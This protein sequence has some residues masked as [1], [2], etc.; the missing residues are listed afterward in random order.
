MPFQSYGPC[1]AASARDVA[2]N[3]CD[4]CGH[5]LLRCPGFAECGVLVDQT[6]YCA[7]HLAPQ[8]F[9]E[10]GASLGARVGQRVAVPLILKNGSRL[11]TGFRVV[12]LLKGE[13]QRELEEVA[14]DWDLLRGGDERP[15]A[16]DTG[17]FEAGGSTRLRVVMVLAVE[18][19]GS[20]DSYAF[21]A[22]VLLK[23]DEREQK[24]QITQHINVQGGHFEAGASAVVQTG[25]S[26]TEGLQYKLGADGVE[27]A[28]TPVTTLQ[29]AE[30]Y[31]L[32]EGVRG[33]AELRA[34]LAPDIVV[35]CDGFEDGEAPRGPRP[36]LGRAALTLGRNSQERSDKNPEPN[37]FV[38]RSRGADGALDRERS[39]AVSGRAGA[40]SLENGR[41]MFEVTGSRTLHLNGAPLE[42][43]ATTVLADG[44]RVGLLGPRATDLGFKVE[45][46]VS[47]D[48]LGTL[49]LTRS[50]A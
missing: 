39:L 38:F 4:Q 17:V 15:F 41:L 23:I 16:V 49:W 2:A 36:F 9:V 48:E 3:V 10:Q 45:F 44:D 27:R 11:G 43:G 40:L 31:E 32:R 33:Y 42:V 7:T 26:V 21:S 13:P 19:G 25:P 8:L 20:A 30:A 12:R 47:G 28:R 5:A 14:L 18:R 37:D 22:E 50:G 29:R 24:A 35:K 6:G 34:A 1:C 46:S